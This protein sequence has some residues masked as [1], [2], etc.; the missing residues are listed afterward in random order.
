MVERDEWSDLC[1]EQTIDQFAVEINPFLIY[2]AASLWQDAGPGSR[3]SIRLQPDLFHNAD[4]F[5]P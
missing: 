5:F 3:K 1:C 4:V 2:P